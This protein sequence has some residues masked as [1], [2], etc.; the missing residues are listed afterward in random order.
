MQGICQGV[1]QFVFALVFLLALVF[2]FSFVFVFVFTCV[3]TG[4]I[5]SLYLHLYLRAFSFVSAF[6][7]AFVFTGRK[8]KYRRKLPCL[9]KE[10]LKNVCKS[11]EA[12]CKRDSSEIAPNLVDGRRYELTDIYRIKEE[13]GTTRVNSSVGPDAGVPA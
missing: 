10:Y 13:I 2:A 8:L 3:F 11:A 1:C 4:R 6:V 9:F 12:G 7:F 5:V